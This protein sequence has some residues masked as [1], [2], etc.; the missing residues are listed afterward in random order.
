MLPRIS[1]TR[2]LNICI[3]ISGAAF[4]VLRTS[5]LREEK[6]PS[7]SLERVKSEIL[8]CVDEMRRASLKLYALKR[9]FF[10]VAL[11]KEKSKVRRGALQVWF[12]NKCDL[13]AATHI[14]CVKG[15]EILL[16]HY[17]TITKFPESHTSC[18]SILLLF[19]WA[20]FINKLPTF[21]NIWQIS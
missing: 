11:K 21:V 13:I 10:Q 19:C 20:C 3:N 14:W 16:T 1:S 9:Q 4:C 17:Y 5:A 2:H 6:D 12:S 18:R 8:L 7:R 15:P